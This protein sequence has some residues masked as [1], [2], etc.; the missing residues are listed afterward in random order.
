LS[1]SQPANRVIGCCA[2]LVGRYPSRTHAF[3]VNEVRALREAGLEIETVSVHRAPTEMVLSD[4]D[5]REFDRTHALRPVSPWRLARCHARALGRAPLAYLRTLLS[6][7]LDSPGG[8][9]AT[10]WQLFYFGEALLLWAWLEAR[11]P[12]HIHVHHANVASDV[13]MIACR[14]ANWGG[15]G[16]D[17]RR[18]TWSLT[19]HGPHDFVD[20]K[21]A[22]LSLKARASA[23]VVCTSDFGRAQLLSVLDREAAARVRT[24]YCG[25]DIDRF[26]PRDPPRRDGGSMMVLTVA[27]LAGRKGI[28]V[29]LDALA[30][31]RD[32][33]LRLDAVI[34]GE[35]EE[36]EALETRSH[37]L[38]L[39][40]AVTFA[41]AMGQDRLPDHYR[42]ADIFCLP[43]FA[44]GMPIV[45][46][47]AMACELPVVTTSVMGVPELVVHRE[48]GLLV[49]PARPDLL[50]DALGE[51]A[52]DDDLRRSL[53]RRARD[54]VAA[55]FEL[56]S[57]TRELLDA[58]QPLATPLPGRGPGA[59]SL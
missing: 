35:G 32:R 12:R 34:V 28:D 20:M 39:D 52:Q 21:A 58:L 44:E 49:P 56:G 50:A 18:W 29:L 36:R 16:D 46:M 45:L 10:L 47:E 8:P 57:A 33:G 51:L 41:G 59:T 6:T 3:I 15:R 43:S 22:K 7:I 25:V 30:G 27:Q 1:A 5:R 54:R 13:A 38:G 48:C 55:D 26:R 4:V 17:A 14:F 24:I 31:L 2:Y 23:G 11:T 9:R 42:R 40:A 53:G 19:V 37:E